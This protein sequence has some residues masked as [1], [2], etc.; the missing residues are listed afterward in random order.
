MGAT[1][2]RFHVV[3]SNQKRWDTLHLSGAI[4]WTEA[5]VYLQKPDQKNPRW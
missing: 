5:E 3:N 1:K 2:T 4:L